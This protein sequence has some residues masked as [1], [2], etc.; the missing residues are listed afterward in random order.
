M[1]M[2]SHHTKQEEVDEN[3]SNSKR[4][5][6]DQ[7]Q[8]DH[9]FKEKEEEVKESKKLSSSWSSRSTNPVLSMEPNLTM[10]TETEYIE[11]N[12]DR[13]R[14]RGNFMLSTAGSHNNKKFVVHSARTLTWFLGEIDFERSLIHYFTRHGL[15]SKVSELLSSQTESELQFLLNLQNNANMWTPLHI[16]IEYGHN[17]IAALLIESG[18]N[19]NLKDKIDRTPLLYCARYGNLEICK[20]LL[21]KDADILAVDC[22]G[23]SCLHLSAAHGNENILRYLIENDDLP[24]AR[25]DINARNTFKET[26]LHKAAR[27]G[28]LQ[29]V[30][31]LLKNGAAANIV[32]LQGSP[33]DLVSPDE[34]PELYELLGAELSWNKKLQETSTKSNM[35]L[36]SLI[37]ETP[38]IPNSLEFSLPIQKTDEILTSPKSVQVEKENTISSLSIETENIPPKF[39]T[40][41]N[42]VS[43]GNS[44]IRTNTRS[45]PY[46]DGEDFDTDLLNKFLQDFIKKDKNPNI[47]V[48]NAVDNMKF[49]EEKVEILSE[50]YRNDFFKCRHLIFATP[51]LFPLDDLELLKTPAVIVIKRE[52]SFVT[53]VYEALFISKWG[54]LCIG[55]PC[56][57][58]HGTRSEKE[59]Y[60][61]EQLGEIFRV[62][63]GKA[64]LTKIENGLQVFISSLTSPDPSSSTKTIEISSSD[65]VKLSSSTAIGNRSASQKHLQFKR[66]TSGFF[67]NLKKNAQISYGTGANLNNWFEITNKTFSVELLGL[68]AELGPSRCYCVGIVYSRPGQT[69]ESEMFLNESSSGFET[70]LGMLGDRI[71]IRGWSGFRGGFDPGSDIGFSY[72]TSWKGFE[73]MFHAVPFL[74]D[75]Q[76]RRL[77]GNDKAIIYFQEETMFVPN[78]R[79]DVNT[80]GIVVQP[81]YS[82]SQTAYRVGCFS[83]SNVRNFSPLIPSGLISNPRKLKNLILTIA[84]NG[85]DATNKSPPFSLLYA[86]RWKASLE[87]LLQRY[88]KKKQKKAE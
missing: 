13:S 12:L 42:R 36:S 72:Y 53:D 59:R 60:S 67:E 41:T 28:S 47:V 71:E 79:G 6:I 5:L 35:S 15:L 74:N 73:I 27:T 64:I 34:H 55:F 85:I 33:K 77:V 40:S 58:V 16:A 29:L 8:N 19:L 9:K 39:D 45:K 18:A 84:L 7:N 25:I 76:R 57:E 10:R 78:F 21:R 11:E 81:N 61:K 80:V 22:Y 63:L 88:P 14:P 48:V 82:T 1:H 31:F 20:L 83:R 4:I 26:C 30:Q 56:N 17:D 69:I 52:P 66:R 75:E 3:I 46:W 51:E 49:T 23:E 54:Y 62:Y 32:A 44:R 37:S 43:S 68:E 24:C 50:P 65:P 70:F 2:L 38:I 86:S 87:S